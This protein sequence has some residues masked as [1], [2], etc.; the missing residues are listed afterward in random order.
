MGSVYRRRSRRRWYLKYRDAAGRWVYEAAYVDR[1]ASEQLLAQRER[2]VERG[3]VGLS[4]PYRMHRRTPLDQH[5]QDFLVHLRARGVT[6]KY[7]RSFESRLKRAFLGMSASTP[8]D[9]SAQKAERFIL[10]LRD[11]DA[12]RKGLSARGCNS[13]VE[14]LR[15]F[16]AWGVERGRWAVSPF[17][18]LRKLNVEADRRRVRRALTVPELRRVIE[19]APVRGIEQYRKNHGCIRPELLA[20]LERL[21]VERAV[22]YEVAAL[23]GLRLNELKTLEWQHI[24][25]D[26]APAVITIAAQHAKSRRADSI[27]ISDALARRLLD[28]RNA[29]AAEQHRAPDPG[30]RVFRIS[31][32]LTPQFERDCKFAKILLK[33]GAHRY[34]DFHSLRHTFAQLLVREGVHPRTAQAMLRHRDIRT[35]MKV[36]VRDDV[37]AQIKAVASLP[38]LVDDADGTDEVQQNVQQLAH[39]AVQDDAT[40]RDEEAAESVHK[41]GAAGTLGENMQ[42]AAAQCSGLSLVAGAGFEPA[43][44]RL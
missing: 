44:F 17:S 5:I 12:D 27:L 35:T 25:F 30:E 23:T 43:I 39:P 7:S 26:R 6:R 38:S 18:G 36:Y 3:E 22:I 29:L 40:P 19:A 10:W 32:R 2:G 11:G 34:V 4:D 37:T 16:G 41:S 13:Y 21:G 33:D 8:D 31:R 24:N 28:W 14:V 1:R 9:L 15:E 42:E 20:R